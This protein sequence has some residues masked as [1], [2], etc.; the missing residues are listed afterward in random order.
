MLLRE[1]L[2]HMYVHAQ[3]LGANKAVAAQKSNLFFGTGL[4]SDTTEVQVI[5]MAPLD[6]SRN[7]RVIMR[8]TAAVQTGIAGDIVWYRA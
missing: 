8:F 1:W 5:D 2:V 6:G 4:L 3:G 7:V